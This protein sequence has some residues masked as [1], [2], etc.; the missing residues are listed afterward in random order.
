MGT[1]I[2]PEQQAAAPEAAPAAPAAPAPEATPGPP[3][4]E[5]GRFAAPQPPVIEPQTGFPQPPAAPRVDADRAVEFYERLAD[6]RTRSEE[7]IR[8]GREYGFV[9]D[10]LTPDQVQE[11][12]LLYQDYQ[13]QL[14]GQPQPQVVGQPPIPAAPLPGGQ[15]DQGWQPQA[16]APTFDPDQLAQQVEQRVMSA[17]EQREEQ[18]KVQRVQEERLGNLQSAIG[19]IAEKHGLSEA[20]HRALLQNVAL[21]VDTAMQEGRQVDFSVE[22]LT[23][24]G[25]QVFDLLRG[26]GATEQQAQTQEAIAHHRTIAPQ[27]TVPTG[28]PQAGAPGG[29]RG[30]QGVVSRIRADQAARS[31][32][33]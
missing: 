30:I 26:M 20:Q 1:N 18:Q 16:L 24:Y 11:A 28:A 33:G 2:T 9:P 23:G 8:V 21:G 27:T 14:S 5:N 15:P 29:P 12:L 13:Q 32:G 7:F 25:Q 4:D 19:S 6:P 3:R 22:A 31:A 10:G 17:W